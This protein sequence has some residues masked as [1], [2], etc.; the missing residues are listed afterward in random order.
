MAVEIVMPHLSDSMEEGT[1]VQWL[2]AK[3][4]AVTEG[5]EI[6]EV[7]T[8]KA[9]VTYES[10]LNGIVLALNAAVGDT[11][12]VGAV[13]AVVGDGDGRRRVK[14]SPLAR[15][16]AAELGV[17]LATLAGSGPHGRVIRS[18]VER[19]GSAAEAAVVPTAIAPEAP[20]TRDPGDP[21]DPGVCQGHHHAHASDPAP[22]DG[23]APD[24]RIPFHR[25]RL[26]AALRG[27]HDPG[28]GA[29]E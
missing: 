16:I 4:D 12:A 26:R 1:I 3:G 24:G 25:A 14:A 21:G 7:E 5:Q 19:S 13:I 2:V 6:V 18:D 22:G 28:G 10:E 29:A 8:D 9:T 23:G 11:V 17:D 15:R 27:G 20:A